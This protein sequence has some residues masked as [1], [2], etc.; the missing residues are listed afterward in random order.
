MFLSLRLCGGV[1]R[2]TGAS[3]FLTTIIF[4]FSCLIVKTVTA[5]WRGY[6]TA[7]VDIVLPFLRSA[8][9]SSAHSVYG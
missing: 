8:Y 1:S 6:R 2:H 7:G 4:L 9:L 5:A 3:Q